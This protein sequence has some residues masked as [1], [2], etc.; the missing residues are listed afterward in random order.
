MKGARLVIFGPGIIQ[1]SQARYSR[2]SSSME[3]NSRTASHA[4]SQR[5]GISSNT[6]NGRHDKRSGGTGSGRSRGGAERGNGRSSPACGASDEA[7]DALNSDQ[8]HRRGGAGRDEK[9]SSVMGE[10]ERKNS[11]GSHGSGG[12]GRRQRVSSEGGSETTPDEESSQGPGAKKQYVRG[13]GGAKGRRRPAGG[14]NANHLL[15]FQF[16]P[17]QSHQGSGN[18]EGSRSKWKNAGGRAGAPVRGPMSKEQF[19]QA[20][21]LFSM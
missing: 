6:R 9:S 17:V 10:N 3:R 13:A 11:H 2:P 8:N 16:Q 20:R 21:L 14:G 15:N 7:H 12:D 1:V 18:S 4:V 5:S 19:L